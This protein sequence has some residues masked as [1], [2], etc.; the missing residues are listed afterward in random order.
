[1]CKTEIRRTQSWL[2]GEILYETVLLLKLF[3]SSLAER[4]YL[5]RN[6]ELFTYSVEIIN[7][8]KAL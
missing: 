1:M 2:L 8:T 4:D 6:I 3:I 5:K 7:V